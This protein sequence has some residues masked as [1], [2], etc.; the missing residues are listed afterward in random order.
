MMNQ[1]LSGFCI[2]VLSAMLWPW[3]PPL[4]SLPIIAVLLVL[5]LRVLSG[6]WVPK[7]S[8]LLYGAL[9]GVLW[10]SVYCQLVIDIKSLT[11]SSSSSETS[12]TQT[13]RG[14]IISLVSA[15]GDW[16][17]M[18][19]RPID[20]NSS[21]L[22]APLASM[23]RLSWQGDALPSP[24][25]GEVWQF[26][27]K[28][29]TFAAVLNQGGFNR[30]RY[31]LG[32]RIAAR[33]QVIS[34]ER[35]L[36][37][38]GLRARLVTELTP[39][40]A[41]I[42]GGDLLLAL[43]LGERSLFSKARWQELRQSGNAH[44]VAISGLHL[45]VVAF[46]CYL[47]SFGVLKRWAPTYGRRNLVLASLAALLMAL[48]YAYLAGFAIATQRALLMLFLLVLSS[49]MM[50]YAS[51]WDRLLWALSCV[52]LI[53]PLASLSG[54]F[55]LSFSALALILLS[56]NHQVHN[57]NALEQEQVLTHWPAKLKRWALAFWAIQWRLCLGLSLL[58]AVL[59]GAVTVHSLW[60]NLLLVPWFSLLVIPLALLA[61]LLWS[62]FSALGMD[63]VALMPWQLASLSLWPVQKL[64]QFNSQLPGG[65]LMLP[66]A[67]SAV[68]LLL[69]PAWL[70][71][72]L[73]PKGRGVAMLLIL[74]FVLQLGLWLG[75]LKPKGWQL[76]M[77]D[78]GQGLAVVVQKGPN[79][80]LYDTGAA[81]GERFSYAERVIVPFL[82]AKGVTKLDFLIVSHGD[83]DHAGGAQ[84]LMQAFD[85]AGLITDVSELKSRHPKRWHR[86]CRP[87][88][89]EWQGIE[90]NF[91]GPE[92]P[93][94]GN[95][96][97]CVLQLFEGHHRVLLPGDI[98][99]AAEVSLLHKKGSLESD[100]L[101]APHHGSRTSSHPEFIGA[102]APK[103]VLFAAGYGN[104]WGFPKEEIRLR[105]HAFGAQALIS[106]ELGQVSIHFDSQGYTV[107][108]YRE[109]LAPFWYNRL[110][111]FG[112]A[113]NPE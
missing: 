74:P 21:T 26:E 62:I 7:G 33:G 85:K 99:L 38:T 68:A 32:E 105:Y 111:G 51:A 6:S 75:L 39:V 13:L 49:L 70:C 50:R 101:L 84:V 10:V 106:G 81:F 4:F 57:P 3:I 47:L 98:E 91:L 100:I 16:I 17:R 90:L 113:G 82:G 36:P 60:L 95:N 63:A 77:L 109:D 1:C 73:L 65:W 87:G 107:H 15:N 34:G 5:C 80:L 110:F 86:G 112:M 12:V 27:V 11:D 96:G 89:F 67:L 31:L 52:L 28:P 29:R 8:A 56:L 88:M 72:R 55:W 25:L 53:D 24:Q 108:S 59:F 45:S 66:Q 102:V 61:L 46:W 97:S 79:A 78:V 48:F 58:Q 20:D 9:G 35:L 103:W 37:S 23:W 71:W 54:G 22:L 30:Q 44:L 43:T 19:I 41:E 2:A 92:Q 42:D 40:L 14:E 64:W 69:F 104:R 93:K 83:N 18:D 76:H 94:P